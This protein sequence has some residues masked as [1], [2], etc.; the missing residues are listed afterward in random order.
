ML[1]GYLFAVV[2]EVFSRMIPIL[3]YTFNFEIFLDLQEK[4]QRRE[5]SCVLTAQLLLKLASPVV[6]VHFET[7]KLAAYSRNCLLCSDPISFSMNEL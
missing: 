5:I 7:K 3:K 2:D 6:T 4:M 1:T